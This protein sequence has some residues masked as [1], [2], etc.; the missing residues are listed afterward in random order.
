MADEAKKFIK[1]FAD[2]TMK[3]ELKVIR[4]PDDRPVMEGSEEAL[5]VYLVNVGDHEFEVVEI[6]HEDEDVHLEGI[7][8][9]QILY[10]NQPYPLRIIFRPRQNRRK[11]LDSFLIIK[12][13]FIIRPKK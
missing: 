8:E 6:R 13:N 2:Q 12:G 3:K 7:N 1:V 11:P 9:G 5:E 10:P 4:F